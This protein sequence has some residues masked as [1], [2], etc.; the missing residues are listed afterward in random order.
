M[1]LTRLFPVLLLL[2]ACASTTPL[3][4]VL[5]GALE[6]EGGEQAW[7]EIRALQREGEL[8]FAGLEGTFTSLEGVAEQRYATSFKLGPYAG[9]E[10][11]D[12]AQA[13]FMDT[14]GD[15]VAQDAAA[16][17]QAAY[18]LAWLAA[19]G[20]WYPERHPAQ[21]TFKGASEHEGR[22]FNVIEAVPEGGRP[23]ELWFDTETRHLVR[24]LEN[25]G[26]AIREMTFLDY[27]PVGAV[28]LPHR[29]IDLDTST[30]Q[31]A[32]QRVRS[33]KLNPEFEND[34]FNMPQSQVADFDWPENA[35]NVELPFRLV[36]NHIY[37]DVYIN[38][39]GP[40]RFMLDTG[41]L[42]L[43]TRS[44]AERLGIEAEGAIKAS[45]TGE[46]TLDVGVANV[47]TVSLGDLDIQKQMFF[48]ADLSELQ[49]VEG[50]PFDGLVGFEVFR[51][52]VV[53]I[54]YSDNRMQLFRPDGFAYAGSGTRIP[55]RLSDR[56]PQTDG[57]VDGVP[58]VFSIDTGSRSS[59]DLHGPFVR[60]HNLVERYCPC[61]ETITGW[62]VGGPVRGRVARI[63]QLK[64]GEQEID[65]VGVELTL[66][67]SGA[68]ADSNLAGNVGGAVLKRFNV[69]FD[70]SRNEMILEPHAGTS[71]PDNIDKSGIWINRDGEK[72]V[73]VAVAAGSAADTAGMHEGDHI[74]SVDG[75]TASN[76]DLSTL[77]QRLR[78]EPEGTTVVF[79]V[80]RDRE[81]RDV[82]I[83]LK[84]LEK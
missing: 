10:G 79:R 20:Y 29:I 61:A 59:L 57:S 53:R 26:K 1:K 66:Q 84:N 68:Y 2:S 39:K 62:G 54:G 83:T 21:L 47:E 5:S 43:L 67:E 60:Q 12:G 51:R 18:N 35:A 28:M 81:E 37:T 50:V 27:R 31:A 64:L 36:N 33:V 77:R 15:A 40:L 7:A 48:V 6:A 22:E 82:P 73:V 46:K 14:S 8:N 63:G 55:I 76:I 44:A 3:E 45:G 69:I 11:F 75:K 25:D 23:M 56:T 30:G 70:Y 78:D 52:F 32:E 24:V 80:H 41:G 17:R 16:D 9:A 65:D 19:R 38:G 4:A 13:W 49:D 71:T 58:G 42:N 74:V 34:A 72:L